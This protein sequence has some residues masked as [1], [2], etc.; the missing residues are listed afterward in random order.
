MSTHKVFDITSECPS[1]TPAAT[2][3]YNPNTSSYTAIKVLSGGSATAVV[4]CNESIQDASRWSASVSTTCVNGSIS[5]G[6]I[7]VPGTCDYPPLWSISFD[8]G[9]CTCEESLYYCDENAGT[10]A[11]ELSSLDTWDKLNTCSD[12]VGNGITCPDPSN[13][14]QF[15]NAPGESVVLIC[16]DFIG[17]TYSFTQEWL[18]NEPSTGDGQP[19]L[20]RYNGSGPYDC[21]KLMAEVSQVEEGDY[22]DRVHLE[23]WNNIA[24]INNPYNL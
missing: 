1:S 4:S 21:I 12:L 14:E 24:D 13:N 6:S 22:C 7:V 8:K 10:C 3:V 15:F 19:N 5:L 2:Y 11:S 17:I 9:N 18:N 16:C 20:S 23:L